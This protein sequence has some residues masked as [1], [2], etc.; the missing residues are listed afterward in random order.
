MAKGVVTD[1]FCQAASTAGDG[2]ER[3]TEGGEEL[4][5][6]VLFIVVVV[7]DKG[8]S[9]RRGENDE[10][11]GGKIVLIVSLAFW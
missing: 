3:Q 2:G 7:R 1:R 4:G 9:A 10:F 5:K 8:I 11:A 6:R